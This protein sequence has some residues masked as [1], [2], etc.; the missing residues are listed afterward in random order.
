MLA[1]NR[2]RKRKFPP[3][4]HNRVFNI[5]STAFT[6]PTSHQHT[7]D[8]Q[9]VS[10]LLISTIDTPRD[11]KPHDA[12]TVLST[13]TQNLPAGSSRTQ[14]ERLMDAIGV[15]I[16]VLQPAEGEAKE[17]VRRAAKAAAKAERRRAREEEARQLEQDDLEAEVEGLTED[18]G[19]NADIRDEED[20]EMD[21][22][23]VGFE[24]EEGMDDR[25]DVEYGDVVPSEEEDDVDEPDNADDELKMDTEE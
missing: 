4:L 23:A 11:V 7:M 9:L 16:G 8:R 10:P 15:E 17:R 2:L 19:H 6:C 24:S 5:S 13:F 12:H 3:T 1:S 20:G 14:L 25:G 21:S 18:A 22:G